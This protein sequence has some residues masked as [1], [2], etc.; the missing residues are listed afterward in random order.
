MKPYEIWCPR[1]CGTGREGKYSSFYDV[2]ECKYCCGKGSLY[3]GDLDISAIAAVSSNGVIGND[4]GLPWSIPEDMK[5]FRKT[6][7]G[8]IVVMGRKTYESIGRPL[9]KRYNIVISRTLSK[10]DGD[11][12]SGVVANSLRDALWECYFRNDSQ[13]QDKKQPV[14]IIGGGEIYK[15]ALPYTNRIYRT[16]I[17]ADF[18]GD[19]RFPEINTDEWKCNSSVRHEGSPP[20]T[21]ETLVR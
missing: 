6:T 14:M 10:I 9:P 16:L 2:F 18:E 5:H 3:P 7:S 17:H 20:F 11:K 15:Q 1:C 21:F 4:N 12:D 19:T 8:S 13:T